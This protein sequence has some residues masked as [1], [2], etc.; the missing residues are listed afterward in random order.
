MTEEITPEVGNSAPVQPQ[1]LVH[2]RDIFRFKG[3]KSTA[4]NL[5]H[6][7]QMEQ[8]GKRITF[9]FYTNAMFVDFDTPEAAAGVFE[10]LLNVWAHHVVE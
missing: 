1:K 4:V 3:E 7:T 5:E 9:S 10:Q 2:K 6:V 8:E